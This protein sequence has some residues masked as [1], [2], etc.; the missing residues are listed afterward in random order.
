MFGHLHHLLK[1]ELYSGMAELPY[2]HVLAAN[3]EKALEW[4]RLAAGQLAETFAG[5][6]LHIG[7][8]ETRELGWGQ[9]RARAEE[10]GV[11]NVYLERMVSVMEM[12][13]PLQRRVMFWG[14]IALSHPEL[15]PK[16]PHDLVAMAWRYRPLEDFSKMILPFRQNGM[17]V[18]VCPGLSS[19]GRI[20]P[21]LSD[22]IVD[23]NDFVRD[24]KR[25]GALGM[26]NCDW[27]DDG[28][29][30]F[31][32]NW[33]AIV[34]SGAAA[35]QPG[36]VDVASFE[37][38][39]DWAFYRDDSQT[40]GSIIR[41]LNRVHDLLKAAGGS[42]AD[43]VSFWLDPFSRHGAERVRKM[44]PAAPEVRRIAEQALIDIAAATPRA[45][46][47]RFTL[48]YLRFAAR[49]LDALGM[50]LEFAKLIGDL[51]R[52]ANHTLT[53]RNLSKISSYNGLVQDLR[54]YVLL[55]RNAY[56]DLWLSENRP[57]FLDSVLVR[58]D[59]EALYWADKAHLFDRA[60]AQYR[61]SQILPPPEELG[62][63]LP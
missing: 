42:D 26:L 40:F 15:I 12:L 49:R 18:F 1:V 23:I 25:H 34:F 4:V 31:H 58:Y 6:F 45:R 41:N 62:L 51:Y 32:M 37:Q 57:Y 7:C 20:F 14:D 11:S 52:E 60:L 36:S 10:I 44:A 16:L 29:A 33:Y 24:G 13:R 48:P 27:R 21:N 59:R 55:L 22:A 8:D 47:N 46:R 5:K 63:V 38:A 54:D 61:A 30:F 50:R 53:V 2:G 19:W 9:S 17:D 43:T 56:R 3:N 35:W 39:F 28:E